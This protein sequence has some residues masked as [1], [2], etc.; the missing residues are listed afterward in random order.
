MC[1]NYNKINVNKQTNKQTN[2]YIILQRQY[3]R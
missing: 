1:V 3:L 2:K